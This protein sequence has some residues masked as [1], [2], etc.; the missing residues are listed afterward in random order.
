M[1]LN[2][3][4]PRSF[5][6]HDIVIISFQLLE[7]LLQ[8]LSRIKDIVYCVLFNQKYKNVSK[9]ILYSIKFIVSILWHFYCQTLLLG[10]LTTQW[11]N[12]QSSKLSL[13]SFSQ[14]KAGIRN[15]PLSR[16]WWR[17]K[18]GHITLGLISPNVLCANLP[19]FRIEERETIDEDTNKLKE[20]N[21]HISQSF[22][23]W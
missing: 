22:K 18:F 16:V 9:D 13:T 5:Q 15:N 14:D 20:I 4:S 23:Y 6:L 8:V 2:Q 11:A 17:A 7:W 21:F 12:R 3:P 1:N 19:N 10:L